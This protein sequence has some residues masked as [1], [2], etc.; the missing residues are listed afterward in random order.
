MTERPRPDPDRPHLTPEEERLVAHLREVYRAPALP[1][2]RRAAF[3]ARLE[4]RRARGLGRRTPRAALAGAAAAALLAGLLVLMGRSDERVT[5]PPA[6][7]ARER[8]PDA[9][10]FAAT[11]SEDATALAAT[12][13]EEAIL[14]LAT[15]EA[16]DPDT[17]LPDEYLAIAG[18]FF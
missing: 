12:T 16:D 6:A 10:T 14:A 11:A 13:P 9:T 1:P 17:S 15:G 5:T 18:L 4:A 3:H 7:A 2:Q 8:G